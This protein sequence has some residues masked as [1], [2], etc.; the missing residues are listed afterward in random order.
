[1]PSGEEAERTDHDRDAAEVEHA[2]GKRRG[3]DRVK[4]G[5]GSPPPP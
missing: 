4:R 5:D 3:I 2:A 1:M